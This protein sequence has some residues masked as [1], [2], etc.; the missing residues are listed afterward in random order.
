MY[1]PS[2]PKLHKLLSLMVSH[3]SVRLHFAGSHL[4]LQPSP[5]QNP[6]G[7]LKLLLQQSALYPPNGRNIIADLPDLANK[8]VGLQVTFEY[9]I[10]NKSFFRDIFI[11]YFTWQPYFVMQ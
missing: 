8:N 11:L 5:Q 10:N 3:L 7:L 4:A 6:R 2:F 9:Q 1:K